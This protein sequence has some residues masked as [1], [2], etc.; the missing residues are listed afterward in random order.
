MALQQ[1]SCPKSDL[2]DRSPKVKRLTA[3]LVPVAAGAAD[4]TL[5]PCEF[6]EE[7]YPEELLIDHQVCILDSFRQEGEQAVLTG[8]S[9]QRP[10]DHSAY[11]EV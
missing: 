9:H 6:C 11:G 7:L 3:L 2:C 4:E 5:L 10:C 1:P 8:T